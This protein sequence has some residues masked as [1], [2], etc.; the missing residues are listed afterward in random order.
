MRTKPSPNLVG[1]RGDV[2]MLNRVEQIF[3]FARRF[4]S[5]HFAVLKCLCTNPDVSSNT[6]QNQ[7]HFSQEQAHTCSSPRCRRKNI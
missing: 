5:T 7:P 2:L 4:K 6:P 3:N 1:G